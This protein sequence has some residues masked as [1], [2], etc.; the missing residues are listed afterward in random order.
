MKTMFLKETL[1]T[2]K[3]S[4]GRFLAIVIIVAVGCGFFAGLR[5]TGVGM[6][7]TADAYFDQTHLY[8][9][10][11]TSSLGVTQSTVDIIKEVPGVGQ[12]MCSKS[13]DAM[14]EIDES[15]RAVRV[16]TLPTTVAEGNYENAD[17]LNQ[18]RLVSGRWPSAANECVMLYKEAESDVLGDSVKILY[19]SQSLD[20][21]LDQ[22][23]FTVVGLLTDPAF[24]ETATI[25]TT[26][27]GSGC[28]LGVCFVPE[29]SFA[30]DSPYTE[31]SISVPAAH[32]DIFGTEGYTNEVT[33]VKNELNQRLED[34]AN[35]RRQEVQAKAEEELNE[36]RQTY[37]KKKAEAY[38]KLD[39]AKA[40]LNSSEATI[41]SK[42]AEITQ[43][44]QTLVQSKSQ[45]EAAYA[46][47]LIPE[48]QYQA[49][50][51]QI[52][53]QEAL[54]EKGQK[55]LDAGKAQ[56]AKGRAQ[57]D[58]QKRVAEKEL[59]DAK[60]QLDDAQKTID[61]IEKPDVYVL[62]LD[63]NYGAT[64]YKNDSERIDKI[65]SVF[66]FF[67]FVVAA[68][69]AL[70]TMMRMVEDDRQLIGTF[71]ALGYSNARIASKY[72]LYAGFAS[73]LGAAIGI[74]IM[75][76]LLPDVILQ[77]YS[78]IYSMP[79]R[80]YPLPIELTP[81][82]WA[83]VLGVGIT[84]LATLYAC[85]SS[86]RETPAIL[87]QPKAPKPGKRIL[88]ERI[89]PLWNRVSFSWKVTLRNIFR[90]KARFFMT[91]IGVAGCTMLLVT[92]FGVRDAIN[93]IIDNQFG[94]SGI[95]RFNTTI[96][97]TDT[98]DA[99][100]AEKTVAEVTDYL[101]AQTGVA[102]I[103]EMSMENM[104]VHTSADGDKN[105]NI[106]VECPEDLES[107]TALNNLR[108][109]QTQAPIS[110]SENSVVLT[111]KIAT[112]LNIKTGDKLPLYEQDKI[113]NPKGSPTFVTVTDICENYLGA[114]LF[115]GPAAYQNAFKEK[116]IPNTL[117]CNI[118]GDV[119]V[120]NAI[121]EH[122]QT[123]ENVDTVMYNDELI[124]SYRNMLKSVDL[125]MVVLIIA[126]MVLAFVVLYNLANINIAERIREI[127]SLKVLGFRRREVSDYVF[128]E[129][130]II[131]AVGALVGLCLGWIFESYV[132]IT[133]EVDSA[134]FGRIIHASSYFISLG[135]TLLF[136]AFVC[137]S[138]LPKLAHIDMVES[139]KSVD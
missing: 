93:D 85:F 14:A 48:E 26:S 49:Q 96:G 37:E 47:G 51:A 121:A 39:D 123:M 78:I 87:M 43:G 86:F 69:V 120:R 35:A 8:D 55:E 108:V 41:N 22:R 72:L 16:T 42:Q 98:T 97:L 132:V 113:G 34:I 94:E 40:K 76:Q 1:R 33:K 15:N 131:V 13:V 4:F 133:A 81:A 28:L 56:L 89:T 20:G 116:A 21:V 6:R 74:A 44:V 111:E 136:A 130:L 27:L 92:G 57:Y 79:A 29:D 70:T 119:D 115:I 63:Q 52:N 109:R 126:A 25:A 54:L 127:A 95:T 91:V 110:F 5:M 7:K 82:I 122:L 118:E 99:P 59:R 138:M 103:A 75:S 67:F 66:P 114:Y 53:A 32:N 100:L 90:Y 24:V 112:T 117:I 77:A 71:K 46:A 105:H 88:L 19:G 18:A 61:D 124:E 104:I 125:V 64:S 107:F 58:K 3:G 62:T 31:V 11:L 101:N 128:R 17:A 36:N 38:Q 23:E 12:T 129:I 2:V 45:L 135:L 137:V 134:M 9:I 10:Q 60:A 50:M 30:A 83:F 80:P 65:A 68:L 106:Q 84:L 102:D 73:A 139:L